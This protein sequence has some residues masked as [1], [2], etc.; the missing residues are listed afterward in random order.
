[1]GG[2]VPC[3]TQGDSL[4]LVP[5]VGAAGGGVRGGGVDEL[6]GEDVRMANRYLRIYLDCAAGASV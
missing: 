3:R 1:M 6:G 5:T 4:P 2:R